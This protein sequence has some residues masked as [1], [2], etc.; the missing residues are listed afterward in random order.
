MKKSLRAQNPTDEAIR[1]ITNAQITYLAPPVDYKS[2]FADIGTDVYWYIS[3]SKNLLN[4]SSERQ[5]AVFGGD[6]INSGSLVVEESGSFGF[7]ISTRNITNLVG[8]PFLIAGTGIS[9]SSDTTGQI[10][11]TSTALTG[12]EWNERLTGTTNGVNTVFNIAYTPTN[13]NSLMIFLNGVLQEPGITQDYTVS[14]TT[15]TFN[16]APKAESKITATYSR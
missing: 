8:D 11:I 12:F 15:I 1:T 13:S 9:L 4:T 14:G 3:G 10:T 6:V 7:G 5:V 2:P 16:T